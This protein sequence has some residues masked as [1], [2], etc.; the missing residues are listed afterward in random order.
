MRGV[1]SRFHQEKESGEGKVGYVEYHEGVRD[2]GN[3]MMTVRRLP[4][5]ST[6]LP[7]AFEDTVCSVL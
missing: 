1:Q 4:E 3:G 2:G 5:E 6:F 7:F